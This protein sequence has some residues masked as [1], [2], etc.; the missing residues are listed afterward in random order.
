MA[1]PLLHLSGG[2]GGLSRWVGG[3]RGRQEGKRGVRLCVVEMWRAEVE[4]MEGG[5]VGNVKSGVGK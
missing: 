3:L 2:V 1:G 5:S 4:V